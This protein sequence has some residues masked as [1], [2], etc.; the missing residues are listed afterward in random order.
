LQLEITKINN[1]VGCTEEQS[2]NEL[3]GK[4]NISRNQSP[5]SVIYVQNNEKLEVSNKSIFFTPST[6]CNYFQQSFFDN[7][8]VGERIEKK[9]LDEK[10][11]DAPSSSKLSPKN[12]IKYNK[13]QMQSGEKAK[14]Q[15]K[16]GDSDNRN[17]LLEN[18]KIEKDISEI[19]DMSQLAKDIKKQLISSIEEAPEEGECTSRFRKVA[20]NLNFNEIKL[21]S[22][23]SKK[24]NSG[25]QPADKK[26]IAN[27]V[28]LTVT[29][30][31]NF[32]C[33]SEIN[34]FIKQKDA[35]NILRAKPLSDV[36]LPQN[37]PQCMEI[38]KQP[39]K[40]KKNVHSSLTKHI[41]TQGVLS[42]HS[43]SLEKD[44][45]LIRREKARSKCDKGKQLDQGNNNIERS[46]DS[47][48]AKKMQ[49]VKINTSTKRNTLH[50][51]V[52]NL[53]ERLNIEKPAVPAST[54]QKNSINK[55][56]ANNNIP[57]PSNQST[58]P[59]RTKASP[60]SYMKEDK[61][62]ELPAKEALILMKA[63][64]AY[65]QSIITKSNLPTSRK[66]SKGK[67]YEIT[68][69][70]SDK[71]NTINIPKQ[72]IGSKEKNEGR[73]TSISK[74]EYRGDKTVVK[75]LRKDS[76][77]KQG[78]KLEKSNVKGVENKE[79]RPL[80]LKK[81]V[82]SVVEMIKKQSCSKNEK[83]IYKQFVNLS[84]K[85]CKAQSNK[86]ISS[87][88]I[89]QSELTNDTQ[90]NS[91]VCTLPSKDSRLDSKLD[92]TVT[93]P[94]VKGEGGVNVR[95]INNFSNYTKKKKEECTSTL[96]IKSSKI[97]PKLAKAG[98]DEDIVE[99]CF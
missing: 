96:S 20:K 74:T 49:S 22:Y 78:E 92:V 97:N 72:G 25:Q 28:A 50:S 58:K 68:I 43:S 61:L 91:A 21:S 3:G 45:K 57:T 80:V 88:Q 64:S 93:V 15:L 84:L 62:I 24:D 12:T 2:D 31:K 87:E 23:E 82:N 60:N 18:I 19:D 71:T 79:N 73:K 52:V 95:V 59:L 94:K 33:V 1:F 5:Q 54:K 89:L 29:R 83:A 11:C 7:S 38:L 53:S 63:N 90:G 13:N 85:Q 8:Q 86:S 69:N 6:I 46:N 81:N 47:T 65:D 14:R 77:G 55:S 70:L 48:L 75:Q 17:K 51:V 35:K 42:K 44:G 67:T 32:S 40:H 99:E 9:V 4:D 37:L 16:S 36:F 34:I 66:N 41:S 26:E 39:V 76:T 98:G 30:D 56:I 27:Q 10:D